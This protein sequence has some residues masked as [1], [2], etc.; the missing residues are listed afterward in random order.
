MNQDN[1]LSESSIEKK[2]QHF[3]MEQVARYPGLDQ[4]TTFPKDLWREMAENRLFGIGVETAYGGHGI[5]FRALAGAGKQLSAHG[6]N[7]GVVMSWLVHEIVASWLITAFG[8]AAQ[9]KNYLPPLA[10][11]QKIACFA[12]SEPGVGAHPK[13][14]ATSAEKKSGGYVIN[15]EKTYLTNG[16][17]A[18]LFVVIVITGVLS[19]KKQFTAFIVPKDTPGLEKTGPMDFP[20]LH[21]CSHGGIRLNNCLAAS[22]Q[23]LGEIGTAYEKM[24]LPFRTVE[25]TLM[26]GPVTGGLSFLFDHFIAQLSRTSELPD[27]EVAQEAASLK[28]SLDALSVISH[29]GA[30][31]LEKTMQ[32]DKLLSM[33]LF[34]RAQAIE[35]LQ[36]IESLREKAG[37]RPNEKTTAMRGDLSAV[38]RMAENVSRIK[39]KNL[40]LSLFSN[41]GLSRE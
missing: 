33:G 12:V 13:H 5:S 7:M 32:S 36:K 22:D 38:T 25:D 39:L 16:P 34:F 28:C 37:V 8:T 1:Y 3:A 11:G 4:L 41:S 2:F 14:L 23:I 9:K 19:G 6:G 17:R 18:D 35:C 15:G 10:A 27:E 30:A 21:P 20:F 24:V 26:T 31:E 29:A 40:G